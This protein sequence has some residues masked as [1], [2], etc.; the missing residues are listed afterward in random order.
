MVELV[1]TVI[2]E[3]E[4]ERGILRN[5]ADNT[6]TTPVGISIGKIQ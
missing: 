4:E 5:P 3:A 6:G 2:R 1:D